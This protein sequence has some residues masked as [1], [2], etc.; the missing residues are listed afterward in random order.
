MGVRNIL[1]QS[2]IVGVISLR[3]RSD[4]WLY[5]CHLSQSQSR[6]WRYAAV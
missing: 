6:D 2:T 3:H 4:A 1:W 5:G